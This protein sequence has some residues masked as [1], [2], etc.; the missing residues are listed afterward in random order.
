MNQTDIVPFTIESVDLEELPEGWKIALLKDIG[1]VRLGKTPKKSDYR[2]DG[3]HRI[4]KFRDI[5]YNGVNYSISKAAYVPDDPKIVRELKKLRVGDVLLTASAH[6]G[7][8]IGKK[9]AYVDHL[10]NI[11][12]GVYFAGELLGIT[13]NPE[14]IHKKWPYLWL[15]SNIG[16]KVVQKFVFGVHLTGGRAQNI[17]IIL[18]PLAEQQRIVARVE[19]LL[20]HVNATRDRLSRV[21]LIMKKFRQA[22][23]AAACSGRLT[24]GWREENPNKLPAC[25]LIQQIK[26]IRQE[27]KNPN[28][29]KKLKNFQNA[30]FEAIQEESIDIPDSWAWCQIQDIT[31]VQLGGTPSRKESTYWGGEISW[32]SSGEVANNRIRT[33][34]EKITVL[35]LKNS[36]AKLY[37][38]GT[39]LIAMIGEGK[40]RGQSAILDIE[41]ATNQNVAGLVF[42]TD[43]IFNEFVW[44]WTLS[45][46]EKTRAV[47]RGGEQPALNGEKV[48][49][50]MLALPPLAEQHEIVRRVGLLFARADAFDQEV[51]AASRRCERLMQAVLGKAFR[52]ELR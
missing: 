30:E 46:Y 43:K 45:Q 40:T 4:V 41:A 42:D 6:S 33:T 28:V 19:A 2:N 35:G 31:Q 22:V 50:L 1:E 51:A 32:I 20:T 17:P 8:Q 27:Q 15:R 7:D 39:V 38:K 26:K 21:P 48:R 5:S 37:P 16:V 14:I 25:E 49:N 29:T 10:P 34:R 3:I 9:C 18:P 11:Q 44:L 47:G 13:G 12:G 23:L 36:N 52:G 24:E